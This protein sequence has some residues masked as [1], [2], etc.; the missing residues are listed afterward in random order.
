MHSAPPSWCP[1]QRDMVEVTWHRNPAQRVKAAWV[2][3]DDN[4][5]AGEW[6]ERGFPVDLLFDSCFGSGIGVDR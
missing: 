2:R 3:N 4:G 6:A 5:Q 1:R